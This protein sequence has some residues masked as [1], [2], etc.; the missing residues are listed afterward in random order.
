MIEQ[1]ESVIKGDIFM[2][3]KKSITIKEIN[4]IKRTPEE[5][6]KYRRKLQDLMVIILWEYN[7]GF[8]D[9]KE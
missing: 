4:Y 8:Y 7:H 1:R 5:E 2:G 6:E 9:K 3:K